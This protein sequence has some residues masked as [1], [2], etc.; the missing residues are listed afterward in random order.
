[1]YVP[2]KKEKTQPNLLAILDFR[3]CILF[4]DYSLTILYYSILYKNFIYY[5]EKSAS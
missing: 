4:E 5:T 1:M 3:F 2:P